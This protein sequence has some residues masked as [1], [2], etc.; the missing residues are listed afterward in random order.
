MNICCCTQTSFFAS[1]LLSPISLSLSLSRPPNNF[2]FFWMFVMC[3]DCRMGNLPLA[4]LHSTINQKCF[5]RL[6][7]YF[8]L[9]TTKTVAS[10]QSLLAVLPPFR[11]TTGIWKKNVYFYSRV[12]SHNHCGLWNIFKHCWFASS[13]NLTKQGNVSFVVCFFRFVFSLLLVFATMIWLRMKLNVCVEATR[14]HPFDSVVCCWLYEWR[15]MFWN[16]NTFI[17]RMYWIHARANTHRKTHTHVHYAGLC[18]RDSVDGMRWQSGC[19]NRRRS[20]YTIQI[21]QIS[22]VRVLIWTFYL[23]CVAEISQNEKTM[24]ESINDSTIDVTLY[25]GRIWLA[26]SEGTF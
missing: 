6:F 19:G 2:N 5:F 10:A 12:T 26:G 8:I 11:V 22:V 13:L 4:T 15:N 24:I 3:V 20:H 9:K 21:V 23:I 1:S 7:F 16:R 18:N 25:N 17:A 14:S